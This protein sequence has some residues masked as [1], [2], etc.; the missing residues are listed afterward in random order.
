MSQDV[1]QSNHLPSSATPRGHHF[2]AA[3]LAMVSG[4]INHGM[5]ST[6]PLCYTHLDIAGI[7]EEDHG[8]GFALPEVT[9]NPVTALIASFILSKTSSS[10]KN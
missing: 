5:N 7:A 8:N 3:Y 9:G 10:S 1:I 2:P 6:Y 4:L